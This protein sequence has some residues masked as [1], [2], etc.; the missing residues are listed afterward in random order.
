MET[1]IS[2]DQRRLSANEMPTLLPADFV[3]WPPADPHIRADRQSSLPASGPPPSDLDR[4]GP[5]PSDPSIPDGIGAAPQPDGLPLSSRTGGSQGPRVIG[6]SD[7]SPRA[8]AGALTDAPVRTIGGNDDIGT[9][10]ATGTELNGPRGGTAATDGAAFDIEAAAIRALQDAGDHDAAQARLETLAEQSQ[11]ALV[12]AIEA[13]DFATAREISQRFQA[14]VGIP[15][16]G[17]AHTPR[18]EQ[19]QAIWDLVQGF[20]TAGAT[21]AREAEQQAWQGH[22]AH[23]EADG[24]PVSVP[25]PYFVGS[26]GRLY[27]K[28]RQQLRRSPITR[29]LGQIA[30]T[31]PSVSFRQAVANGEVRRWLAEHPELVAG[32][33]L[34][35]SVRGSGPRPMLGPERGGGGPGGDTSRQART[36]APEPVDQEPISTVRQSYGTNAAATSWRSDRSSDDLG[37]LVDRDHKHEVIGRIQSGKPL[38]FK[39][40]A[41][42]R[43]LGTKISGSVQIDGHSFNPQVAIIGSSVAGRKY[44]PGPRGLTGKHDG[45]PFDQGVGKDGQPKRSDWDIAIVDPRLA[46]ALIARGFKS[47]NNGERVPIRDH[48]LKHVGLRDLAARILKEHGREATFMVYR[49]A[50]TLQTRPSS[51]GLWLHRPTKRQEQ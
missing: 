36:G 27:L 18:N 5:E 31:A 39:S 51:V 42:A 45:P 10:P 6:A 20:A 23:Q 43:R 3:T 7:V 8:P 2:W 37:T 48:E 29:I 16:G 11:T 19:E 41:E 33:F 25:F 50:K 22:V 47:R 44:R 9:A 40:A 15:P 38:G 17:L 14:L 32:L 34:P 49:N 35:A 12:A 4:A 24:L 30:E 21:P 13:E 46:D 1:L 28:Q 26:D